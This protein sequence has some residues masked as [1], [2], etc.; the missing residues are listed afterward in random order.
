MQSDMQKLRE[1]AAAAT[2]TAQSERELSLQLEN[3]FKAVS[4]ELAEVKEDAAKNKRITD[5]AINDLNI[6]L[7]RCR[8]GINAMTKF[9]FDECR[10]LIF[11][12]IGL[13]KQSL[14]SFAI[15]L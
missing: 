10:L 1:E 5:K 7:E 4:A 15:P 9:I 8:K 6:G 3:D 13:E 12:S 14:T 2:K 11:D